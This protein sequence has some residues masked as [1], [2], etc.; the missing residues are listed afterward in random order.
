MASD[1]DGVSPDRIGRVRILLVGNS[2]IILL[3][4]PPCFTEIG[5]SNTVAFVKLLERRHRLSQVI[6]GSA[7]CGK[8]SLGHL[9]AHGRPAPSVR[10][11]VGCNTYVKVL[12]SLLSL[13]ATSCVHFLRFSAL[14]NRVS[15]TNKF[16]EAGRE[17]VTRPE[18]NAH[19]F[20][21]IVG[22]KLSGCSRARPYSSDEDV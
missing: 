4:C 10:Q 17:Q 16:P 19:I 1:V 12:A 5:E 8:S 6:N 11:T 2:G 9:L 14:Q 3:P 20:R 13:I 22:I 18:R 15:A 7:G 21:N